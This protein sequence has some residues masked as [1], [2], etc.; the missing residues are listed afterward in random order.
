VYHFSFFFSSI[1]F[2]KKRNGLPIL[3]EEAAVSLNAENE[4]AVSAA[5]SPALYK[6]SRSH[7]STPHADHC[8]RGPYR[9]G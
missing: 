9:R 7:H 1:I 8:R 3:P 6:T 4:S 5:P 2:L